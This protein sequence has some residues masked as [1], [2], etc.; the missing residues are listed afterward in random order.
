MSE[1]NQEQQPQVQVVVNQ[2]KGNGMGTAGFV[3]SLLSVI[4]CWIPV[5]N[6]VSAITGILGLVFSIIGVCRAPRGL[7]IAGLVLSAV[8]WILFVFVVLVIIADM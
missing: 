4:F 5:L 6:F 1:L 7:A 2:K 8:Y 3:L